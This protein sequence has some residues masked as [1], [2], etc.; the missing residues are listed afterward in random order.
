MADGG[1]RDQ[2]LEIGLNGGDQ[3]AVNDADNRQHADE[4]GHAV[5]GVRKERQAEAHHA[6][7]TELQHYARE[8]HGAGSGRFGVRV[9]QPCVQREQRHFNGEREEESAEEPEFGV[10]RKLDEASLQRAVSSGKSK[11]RTRPCLP[12]D[13][14][15]TESRPASEL[16]RTWC[17][18]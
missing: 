7:G 15:A 16:N 17:R 11:V 3:R 9:R 13:C 1:V 2:P 10:R 4:W 12:R 18:E 5:R 6:V 8:N 14:K